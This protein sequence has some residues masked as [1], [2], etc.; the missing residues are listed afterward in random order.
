MTNEEAKEKAPALVK[1]SEIRN[2]AQ[3]NIL[4]GIKIAMSQAS[5]DDTPKEVF[6]EMH[7][8]FERVAKLFGFEPG[9]PYYI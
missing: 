1:K 8:Q 2:A 9:G 3:E 4:Y 6:L 7:R 5:E